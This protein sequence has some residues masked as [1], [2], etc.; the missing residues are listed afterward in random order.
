MAE[1]GYHIAQ[2]QRGKFGEASKILEEADEFADATDQK[3][4]LMQL[5]ELSDMVGAIKGFLAKHHPS[6]TIHDLDDM[7][8]VTDR[9]FANGHRESRS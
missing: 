5:I 1:P 4:V 7:A 3:V 6:I 9:V 2:I 8:V